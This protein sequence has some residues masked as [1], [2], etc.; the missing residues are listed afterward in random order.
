MIVI[1][2]SFICFI[3]HIIIL[4]YVRSSSRRVQPSFQIT[5]NHLNNY[6]QQ[7]INRRDK[8]P[9]RHMFIMFSIFVGG[10]SPIY[11]HT[12]II[13]GTSLVLLVPSLLTL[14]AKLS[15]LFDI[16]NLFIYNHELR[17]YLQN[18]I[19]KCSATNVV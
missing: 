18:V 1:I 4:I 2:P 7:G 13:P 10:W 3:S 8:H 9:L 17:K 11:I 15:L 16:I 5:T 14:L 12:M 19:F 6:Q